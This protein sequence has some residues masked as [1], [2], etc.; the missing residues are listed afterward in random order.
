METVAES[1]SSTIR[2]IPAAVSCVQ[3][4]QHFVL[5]ARVSPVLSSQ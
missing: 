5:T 1:P 2:A 4:A 3:L